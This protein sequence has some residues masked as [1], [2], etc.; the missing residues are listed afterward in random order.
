[1]P[2]KDVPKSLILAASTRAEKTPVNT[3]QIFVG[4][5]AE[6]YSYRAMTIVRTGEYE[7]GRASQ[8]Y[9]CSRA[10][11]RLVTKAV[12][13]H[14]GAKSVVRTITDTIC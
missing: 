13:K 11:D 5:R 1:M 8:D 4:D 2:H 6:I 12:A 10:R 14:A 9:G 3:A 7:T